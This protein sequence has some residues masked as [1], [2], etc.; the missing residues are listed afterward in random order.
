M[1]SENEIVNG[2][3]R[4]TQ[5]RNKNENIYLKKWAACR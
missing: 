1:K 4:W 5:V 3:M 2:S